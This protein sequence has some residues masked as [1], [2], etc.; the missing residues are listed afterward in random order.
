MPVMTFSPDLP[1]R[2]FRRRTALVL[3]AGGV[4][5]AAWMTGAL[6]CLQERLP[7][8]AADA[9][10]IV[11]PARAACWRPHCAAGQRSRR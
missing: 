1:R 11:G 6:T 8:P 10:L 7:Q 4:L 9:D 2:R 5:G 3:G